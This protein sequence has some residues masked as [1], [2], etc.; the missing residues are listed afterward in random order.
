MRAF[1]DWKAILLLI[2]FVT[3]ICGIVMPIFTLKKLLVFENS[4]SMV[5]GV[6]TLAEESEYLLALFLF[7]FSIAM[8]IVKMLFLLLSIVHQDNKS[9]QRNYVSKLVVIG[10][11]SMADVFVIAILAS[12]VKFSGLATVDVH[13]GLAFFSA[14]VAVSLL[15]THVILKDYT[16][17]HRSTDTSQVE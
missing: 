15:L 2:A 6:I 5:G 4:F 3:F 10:K 1:L 7:T 13:I 16:L 9:K 8:P 14:S 12:T 11:W 17:V